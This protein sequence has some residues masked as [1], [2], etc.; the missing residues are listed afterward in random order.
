MSEMAEYQVTWTEKHT[1]RLRAA[2]KADAIALTRQ[3][4]KAHLWGKRVSDWQAC[5][6]PAETGNAPQ[7]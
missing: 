2:S 6:A 3:R 5:E 4:L 1:Y 7:A